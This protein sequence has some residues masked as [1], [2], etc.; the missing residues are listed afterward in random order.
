MGLVNTHDHKRI[1][2]TATAY[3]SIS[4]FTNGYA[5][6]ETEAGNFNFIRTDGSI[7]LHQSVRK[8]LPFSEN[9]LAAVK[10]HRRGRELW[11]FVSKYGD[12]IFDAAW[13]DVCSYNEH[14]V[15]WVKHHADEK[16]WYPITTNGE[17]IGNELFAYVPRSNRISTTVGGDECRVKVDE[18][19]VI[20]ER[21]KPK[22]ACECGTII[23]WQFHD[24]EPIKRRSHHEC[25]KK[26]RKLKPGHIPIPVA[27]YDGYMGFVDE[28]QQLMF[29]KRFVYAEEFVNGF[30]VVKL[31]E[32][33]Y[34]YIS[35]KG[36]LIFLGDTK[37]Y[38][39]WPFSKDGLAKIEVYNEFLERRRAITYMTTEGEVAFD[40]VWKLGTEFIDGRAWVRDF[41]DRDW[42]IDTSGKIMSKAYSLDINSIRPGRNT[43]EGV[44]FDTDRK[45]LVH[46]S[47]GESLDI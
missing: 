28:H 12:Y 37:I 6:V 46:L 31:S 20:V 38:E 27:L 1:S 33:D 45:V 29:N 47:T 11:T 34:N 32:G 10:I 21:A 39:A 35:Q 41:K 19:G 43:I 5:I 9:G 4:K 2:L 15:A 24:D 23:D 8:A 44:I 25:C 3:S 16:G 42:L 17:R 40:V 22:P 18:Y 36:E 30:A 14:G 13:L 7:L 26:A